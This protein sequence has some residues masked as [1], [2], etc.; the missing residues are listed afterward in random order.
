MTLK[1]WNEFNHGISNFGD[2][3]ICILK[4]G[5]YKTDDI[6]LE[7]TV[8]EEYAGKIFGPYEVKRLMIGTRPGTDSKSLRI[9]L[10]EPEQAEEMGI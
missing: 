10:W 5:S 9:P 8:R 1:E 3:I 7:T 4:R 2:Y 6:I